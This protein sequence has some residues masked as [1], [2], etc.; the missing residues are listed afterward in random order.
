MEA[1]LLITDAATLAVAGQAAMMLPGPLQQRHAPLLVQLEERRQSDAS[2]KDA[3]RQS[4]SAVTGDNP[5]WQAIR[6]AR[7]ACA[8]HAS[9]HG[10]HIRVSPADMCDFQG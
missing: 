10:V 7:T 8:R 3:T 5:V 6:H 9:L 1:L 2:R 4:R